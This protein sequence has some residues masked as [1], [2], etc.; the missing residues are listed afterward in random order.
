LFEQGNISMPTGTQRHKANDLRL[1]TLGS[2]RSL[3]EQDSMPMSHRQGINA[4][5]STNEA[6][7]RKEAAENGVIL[8]KPKAPSNKSS[9]RRDR[10]V[11]AP[12]LGKFRG[13]TLKL[14]RRD[15]AGMQGS[16]KPAR[17]TKR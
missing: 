16:G 15:M 5:K 13:G 6:R 1:Q 4:K 3:F 9:T 17:R 11:D 8:E 2:R 14:S 7:R 12:S 10:G